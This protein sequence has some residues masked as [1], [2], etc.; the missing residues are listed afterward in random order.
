VLLDIGWIRRFSFL[1]GVRHSAALGT[2]EANHSPTDLARQPRAS[3]STQNQA[4]CAL[5]SLYQ[6]ML[7]VPLEQNHGVIRAKRPKPLPVVLGRQ[8]IRVVFSFLH[9]ATLV[10]FALL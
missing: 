8:E 9:A 7:Q 2:A 4:F 10:E 1:H 6:Q 5:L 3:A